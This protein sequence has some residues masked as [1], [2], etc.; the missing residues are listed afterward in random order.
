MPRPLSPVALAAVAL[1]AMGCGAGPYGHSRVYAPLD[2]E[3]AAANGADAFDPVMARRDPSLWRAKKVSF[4]GVVT[5]RD[6]LA[7]H[8]GDLT[9]SVRTLADRNLCGDASDDSC[10]VTVSSHEFDVVHA[11]VAFVAPE[12][13]LGEHS[14]GVG[15]LVRVVGTIAADADARDGSLVVDTSYYR[16]WPRG[17]YVTDAAASVLRR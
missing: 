9:L 16:H 14:I 11:K 15:S 3:A 7:P 5:K 1:V 6:D 4:F 2:A 12:D 13:E 10:R 17:F 8:R